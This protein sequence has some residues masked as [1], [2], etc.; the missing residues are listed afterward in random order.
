M[1]K[2]KDSFICPCCEGLTCEEAGEDRI[3]L[4]KKRRKDFALMGTN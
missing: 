4:Q 3:P 1:S 2:V